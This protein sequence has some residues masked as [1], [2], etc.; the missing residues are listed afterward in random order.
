MSRCVLKTSFIQCR[1]LYVTDFDVLAWTLMS[2]TF[3]CTYQWTPRME[4]P[5][6][7]LLL[8]EATGPCWLPWG[9]PL[10]MWC[11]PPQPGLGKT[12]KGTGGWW[13]QREALPGQEMLVSWSRGREDEEEGSKV[14]GLGGCCRLPA[15]LRLLPSTDLRFSFPVPS[16]LSPALQLSHSTVTL[17]TPVEGTLGDQHSLCHVKGHCPVPFL[18]WQP[19]FT[20]C[21]CTAAPS[22]PV[23]SQLSINKGE[24]APKKPPFYRWRVYGNQRPSV[25]G[26]GQGWDQ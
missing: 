5:Q 26:L 19:K 21:A 8:W 2:S 17:T 25:T 24:N 16:A 3:S 4:V 20:Q 22:W 1:L 6:A 18:Q 11:H 15:S 14:M 23:T 10:L 13:L 7:A 9:Q 12:D